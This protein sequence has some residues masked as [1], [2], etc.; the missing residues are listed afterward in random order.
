MQT[1]QYVYDILTTRKFR[2]F[3]QVSQQNQKDHEDM[4]ARIKLNGVKMDLVTAIIESKFDSRVTIDTLLIFANLMAK[5]HGLI[6][7]RLA[8]RN[9]TALLCWYTENWNIIQPYINDINPSRR[10]QNLMMAEKEIKKDN[11]INVDPSD[12]FQL[13]NYH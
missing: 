2:K 6:V 9:K 1:M 11:V 10:E 3:T 4:L 12:L 7:D 8:R 13:L 5:K